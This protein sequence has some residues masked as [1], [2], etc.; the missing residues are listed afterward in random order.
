MKQHPYIKSISSTSA[1][2]GPDIE[3]SGNAATIVRLTAE[4][5]RLRA[6]LQEAHSAMME[7]SGA[8]DSFADMRSAKLEAALHST[9]RA[10]WAD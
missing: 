10:L 8:A 3:A 9:R 6:A 5:D 1:P 2:A 7:A 4:R